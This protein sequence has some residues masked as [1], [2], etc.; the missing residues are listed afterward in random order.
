M[1]LTKK[2]LSLKLIDFGLAQK[3]VQNL[4]QENRKGKKIIGSVN[5]M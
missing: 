3:W 1:F 5:L 4:K 2:T